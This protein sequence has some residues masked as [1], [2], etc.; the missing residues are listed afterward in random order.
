MKNILVCTDFSKDAYCALHYVTN[1][2]QNK[3]CKFSIL[4]SYHEDF[5]I[6]PYPAVQEGGY[7]DKLNAKQNSLLKGEELL[8]TIKR[9]NNSLAHTYEFINTDLSLTNAILNRTSEKSVDLVVLGNHGLDGIKQYLFGSNSLNVLKEVH[10]VPVLMVPQQVDF[11]SPKKIAFATDYK[12]KFHKPEFEILKTCVKNFGAEVH[13]I[14]VGKEEE[15]TKQQWENFNLLKSFFQEEDR[16]FK[17]LQIEEENSK[18][19]AMHVKEEKMDLLVMI[20]YK[21][22]SFK[23]FRE[24][25]IMQLDRHLRFPFLIIPSIDIKP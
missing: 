18:A 4:H 22:E 2:F 11:K 19:I 6:Y 3:S 8:H 25:V 10:S 15:M 21:H 16:N 13:F 1:L 9:D 17:W 12:A 23:F 7:I 14:C 20:K 5:E 24:P